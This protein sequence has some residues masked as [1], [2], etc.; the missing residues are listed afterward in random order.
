MKHRILALLLFL[1]IFLMTCLGHVLMAGCSPT[2]ANLVV[3]FANDS[4]PVLL[5]MY[6]QEGIDA[7]DSVAC[8]AGVDECDKATKTALDAVD[9]RWAKIW[10]AW[11]AL[12]VARDDYEAVQK[13][14]RVPDAQQL[15]R[16]YCAFM[17]LIP[18]KYLKQLPVLPVT[19]R[20]V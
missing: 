18:N 6:R 8:D 7:L 4:S 16:T 3:K 1:S 10:D 19:V 9:A 2:T 15:E 17:A 13:T 20:C 11:D 12:A 5:Q 14:G